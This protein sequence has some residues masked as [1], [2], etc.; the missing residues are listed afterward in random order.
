MHQVYMITSNSKINSNIANIKKA[1]LNS[2]PLYGFILCLL[3]AVSL[4]QKI[5]VAD[6]T[7]DVFVVAKVPSYTGIIS[8]L[9]VLIWCYSFSIAF[10]SYKILNNKQGIPKLVVDFFLFSSGISLVLLLDDFFMLHEGFFPYRLN[11]PENVVYLFYILAF[12]FY[13]TRFRPIIFSLKYVVFLGAF[14]AFMMLSTGIDLLPIEIDYE[15][16]HANNIY[17]LFEDGCKLLAIASWC[18]YLNTVCLD[19]IHFYFFKLG[20]SRERANERADIG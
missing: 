10:F 4:Q 3:L 20:A 8:N 7:K 5:P 11:I 1:L 14:V 17:F 13:V 2:L 12:T 19:K 18:I 16:G 9:G 15:A 6:L